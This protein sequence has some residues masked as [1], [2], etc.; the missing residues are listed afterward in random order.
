VRFPALAHGH[1]REKNLMPLNPAYLTPDPIRRFPKTSAETCNRLVRTVLVLG[2]AGY[3][4]SVMVGQL[5]RRGFKVRVLDTCLFGS[6]SLNSFLPH[7]NFRLDQADVRDINAVRCSMK[8]CDAVI[9]LAAI[10]GD[11]ACEEQKA[12]ALEVNC[13]A[14][15]L[16]ANAARDCGVQRL[17]FASSCSVYGASDSCLDESSPLNP[18]SLYAR[19]K[20]DSETVL[21]TAEAADFAPTALRL[22]TLFGLSPRMRFD[23]IVNL[24]VNQ[25]VSS[26]RV[27][28]W[29]GEQWR[30]F[31]HVHDAA[32]AFVSCLDATPAAVSGQIFNVGSPALNCQIRALGEEVARLVPNTRLYTIASDDRRNYRV[33][34]D[35]IQGVLG[36][37]CKRNLAFGIGEIYASV[38]SSTARDLAGERLM[39]NRIQENTL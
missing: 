19:T 22:G 7:P 16:L 18:L 29:N 23:L 35:K 17:I 4:G 24:F 32:R 2:G 13:T 37:Q 15:P 10:V 26:G 11:A 34:F 21:L 9:H 28:V 38:R 27:T 39:L 25:A 33:S 20:R 30:P 36:F 31:L 1:S 6:R 8:G 14:T 12:L 3:L 5:L